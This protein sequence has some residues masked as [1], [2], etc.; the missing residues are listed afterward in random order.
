MLTLDQQIN[1]C[2]AVTYFNSCENEELA[3]NYAEEGVLENPEEVV[4]T[5]DT[6]EDFFKFAGRR[7]LR[8]GM[9]PDVPLELNVT[10]YGNLYV[11]DKV[12]ARKGEQR[13]TL[14]VMDFGTA[15]A[16]F[17]Y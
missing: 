12:Q 3:E 15:R 16:S 4:M 6:L 17:L 2:K 1:F 5:L 10:P 14:F 13:K 8:N 11:W 7:L 9:R